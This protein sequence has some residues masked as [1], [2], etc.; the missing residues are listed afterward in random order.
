L[1]E[2]HVVIVRK[3]VYIALRDVDWAETRILKD[4]NI[5]AFRMR[6]EY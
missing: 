6:D 2:D 4:C 5:R 1:K 3:L